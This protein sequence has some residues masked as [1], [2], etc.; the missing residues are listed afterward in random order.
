NQTALI[1]LIEKLQGLLGKLPEKIRSPVLREVT[2]LKE[3]F[4]QKRAPRLLFVG[5]IDKPTPELLEIF[6]QLHDQEQSSDAARPIF[7]WQEINASA[8]G[9]MAIL[10]ARGALASDRAELEKELKRA[11][12][13]AIIFLDERGRKM[14]SRKTEIRNLLACLSWNDAA[15]RETKVVGVS[16]PSGRA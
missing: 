13:D 5:S 2:P 8:R 15:G 9:K 4:L 1:N 10:D 6:F 11:P 16:F 3:L 12:A 7:Q 14:T